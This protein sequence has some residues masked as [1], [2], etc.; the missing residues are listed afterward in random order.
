MCSSRITRIFI[1]GAASLCLATFHAR[2]DEAPSTRPAL[3]ELNRE[4]HSLYQQAQGGLLHMQLPP[5]QWVND[6]TLEPIN[7]YQQLDPAVKQR[8]AEQQKQ[9][10]LSQNSQSNI[11]FFANGNYIVQSQSP[12]NNSAATQ[13]S[14]T[15][16]GTIIV[17]QPP[18]QQVAQQPNGP[19]GAL[20]MDAAPA[21]DFAPTHVGLVLGDQGHVLV[22]IY[23]E[24]ETCA[25]QPIRLAM[26]T[27]KIVEAKFVGSDRQTNL[28]VV[29]VD[30]KLGPSMPLGD[31]IEY[32]SVC[33]FVSPIDGAARLGVWTGAEHDWGYVL[34]TDGHIA[35]VA[36]SGEL[37]T[38]SA[39][40]LIASE[41]EQYGAVR[42]P[43][44]GV[45]VREMA[46]IDA[47]RH[48]RRVMRVEGV[49]PNSPAQ[50]AGLKSGDLF[51]SFRGEPISD[52]SS[53]AAAMTACD[54]KTPIQILRDD[55]SIT[56]FAQ[57]SLPVP[58]SSASRQPATK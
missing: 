24:R 55:E 15:Q 35:G 57:L 16:P 48:S 32:G 28:T 44:L 2:A 58:D 12:A 51:E 18:S 36:R 21:A 52:A 41:I 22:P 40:R 1:A 53:L 3:Q 10:G 27:G 54:G 45:V 5:P 19:G 50:K 17:V 14:T 23:V 37:L 29:Q 47:A 33:L 56:L 4:I 26:G 11:R 30:G 7:K 46:V 38:G 49:L 39:C 6:Y 34:A 8:I 9:N 31:R 42:R 13:P 43:T 25:A 20:Q